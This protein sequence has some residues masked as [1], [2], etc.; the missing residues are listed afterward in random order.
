VFA[1]RD[2]TEQYAIEQLRSDF[3]STV[4][5]EL[6]T[7]LAAI[8][9]AA[10]TLQRDDVRLEDSQRSGL[11]DVISREADRLAR[12]VNDILWASRLDS[13]QMGITIESCDAEALT[14]QVA[15]ALRAHAPAGTFLEVGAEPG[16]PA[17]AADPDKLRQVLTNLIDNAVK[18]SPDG[19]RVEVSVARVGNRIRFRVR[20][21]GLGVPPAEQARIFEKFFR[22][23]PQ[24]TRGVG[25]TGLGLYICRELVERMHGRIGVDS[26]GRTGSTFW[27]ELPVA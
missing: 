14:T 27:V 1:F 11:L 9:G 22:L 17:V 2:I 12:I 5:H 4:S 10:L 15:D 19:G 8:Y 13:G 18:Y 7:P 26:D 20:D 25:G 23:D 21:A 6:R 3:V 24:L 16:L